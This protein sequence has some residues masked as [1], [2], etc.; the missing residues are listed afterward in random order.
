MVA[1]GVLDSFT[2]ILR[3]WL[4]VWIKWATPCLYDTVIQSY[5][6]L[7]SGF[8]S[9]GQLWDA[10]APQGCKFYPIVWYVLTE[11]VSLFKC[12]KFHISTKSTLWAMSLWIW[13][14]RWS[15]MV[16]RAWPVCVEVIQDWL[17]AAPSQTSPPSCFYDTSILRYPFDL[18]NGSLWDVLLRCSKWLLWAWL[19]SFTMIWDADWSSESNEPAPL[20]LWHCDPELCSIAKPFLCVGRPIQGAVLHHWKSMGQLWDAPAP[21][22]ATFTPFWGMVLQSLP[23]SSSVVIHKFYEILALSY[24]PPKFAQCIV[25]G[26][27]WAIIAPGANIVPR[28]LI[29]VIAHDSD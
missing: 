2:M 21:R 23:A 4:V 17:L 27:F 1:R 19:D 11:P 28:S 18:F 7:K 29:K 8:K 15:T 22:G 20:S 12:G 5:V 13:L 16:A 10:L 24:D 6:Q 3:C 9:M 14:L 26:T 25:N